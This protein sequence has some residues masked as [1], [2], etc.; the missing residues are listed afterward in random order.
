MIRKVVNKFNINDKACRNSDFLYW[1]KKLP[2][3]RIEAVEMLRRQYHGS[4]ERLQRVVRIV[5]QK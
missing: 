1:S 2:E 3:E 4:A 5:K